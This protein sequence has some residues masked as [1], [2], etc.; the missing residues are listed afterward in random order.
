MIARVWKGWTEPEHADEY[1][2]LLRETVYPGLRRLPGYR[3]GYILR[4]SG[5]REVEFVTLNLFDS[6]DAVRVFAG[7]DYETPVFEPEARR[8]LPHRADC[9]ALRRSSHAGKPGG[10]TNMRRMQAVTAGLKGRMAFVTGGGRWIGAAI[11]RDLARRANAAIFTGSRS[12][13]SIV[14]VRAG[15][16]NGRFPGRAGHHPCRMRGD[17]AMYPRGDLLI[18]DGEC[19]LCAR[20]VRFV[21]AREAEPRLRFAPLRSA[22]GSRLM[23]EAG[24]DPENATTFVV[25]SHG[26]VYAKSDA[27]LFVA[28]H[29]RWP[30]TLLGALRW[31]PRPV[32]DWV[33]ELVARNR[34]RLF[35]RTT[36]CIPVPPELK[37]RFVEE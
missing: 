17:T 11:W 33:Y 22:A 1:E 34:Y 12:A 15:E 21:V 26:R 36:A 19:S 30:W 28:A 25:L 32:R 10:L 7:P 5:A 8:L 18:F 16:T 9:A 27:A 31:V 14:V 24:I 37:A 20:V 4:L 3:G 29:L 13:V 6:L 23:R 2:R 35:G